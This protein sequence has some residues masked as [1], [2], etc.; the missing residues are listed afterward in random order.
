M[1]RE[2][3]PSSEGD[4]LDVAE[5]AELG[6]VLEAY[7]ADIEAGRP[8]ESE[9]LLAAHP[10][11]A[12]QLRACL[13]VMNLADRMVDVT[14]SASGEFRTMRRVDSTIAPAGRSVLSTLGPGPLPHVHLRDLPDES[15]PLIQPRSAEMPAQN[16]ASLGRYQLQGEIA[17][18]GMG[19][20]LKGRDV[21]LGRELAIK[22]LL[23]S[24]HDNPE[25]VSRFIEEAQ[26]GGQLQHPGIVPV[27][28]LGTF[29]DRRPY[30]AMKLVKGKTLAALLHDRTNPAHDLHRF[31]AIFEAVCQT[32][33]YAHARGVLHRDL[34]PSNVMVGSFG[35]VQVM[36][37][38]LA[39][40]LAS[41]GI[42]DEPANQQVQES[43]VVTDRSGSSRSGESQAGSVLGTPAYMAPEQAR[44][45]V[46]RVDERTDVFGLGAI[47]CEILTGR[48]PFVGSTREEIRGKAA[49]G[50]L[51]DA[52]HRLDSCAADAELIGHAHDCLKVKRD[53]RP[54]NAGEV[55]RRVTAFLASVQERLRAAEI[56]RVEAQARSAEERKRWQL[57]KALAALA[58][59]T[60][61]VIGG[62]WTYL[63]RQR[64]AQL[65][66]TTRLVTD[67]LAEAERFR[68][69][70]QSATTEDLS[71]WSEAI[72]AARHAHALVAD[73]EA[74]Q[75]LSQRV[76]TALFDIERE[77]DAAEKQAAE[78][79]RDREFVNKLE[80]IRVGR[81]DHWDPKQTD[82]EYT[83]AFRAF[84]IDFDQV[85]SKEGGLRIA[86]RSRPLEL[87]SYLDDWA[88]M[89]R[90]VSGNKDEAS[91]RGLLEAARAADP[92]PWR[93][94]LRAGIGRKGNDL[95]R[96]LA[97]D[98]QALTEQSTQSLLLL[99]LGLRDLGDRSR[100][101]RV[102]QLARRNLPNDFW[103]NYELGEFYLDAHSPDRPHAPLGQLA[104]VDE[105]IRYYSVAIAIRP[106]CGP[107]HNNLGQCL[108]ELGR[109]AEATAEFREAVRLMPKDSMKH[110]NLGLALNSEGKEEE[111]I[112]ELREA[113]R[114]KPDYGEALVEMGTALDELGRHDEA[115]RAYGEALRLES[116]YEKEHIHCNLG[117]SF[118]AKG[119]MDE[120]VA[121]Y[122]EALR[123]KPDDPDLHSNLGGVLFNQG[124]LESAIAE[125]REALRLNSNHDEAHANLAIAHRCR[126]EYAESIA[127]FRAARDLAKS[128]PEF[129]E[130][131]ELE[132][133]A[134]EQHMHLAPRLPAVLAGTLEPANA[135][136]M[137][138][139]AQLSYWKKLNRSSAQLW[140]KAFQA[141]PTLAQDLT[142]KNRRNAAYAAAL[143]GCGQG[144]VDPP[145]D[146]AAKAHWRSQAIDWL[147]AD[148]A[149]CAKVLDVGPPE[150]RMKIRKTLKS[151]MNYEL[152][153][154][155]DASA[156]TKFPEEEQ[157]ACRAFWAEV[158]ALL[159]K[160]G[161]AKAH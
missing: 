125:Y 29:P 63:A 43:V 48:P 45:E 149:S 72:A 36:D 96:K 38:G 113:L 19:A 88:L 15:D 153:G 74:D 75:L 161:K 68:G 16:G 106:T 34:K 60:T 20:I 110:C 135:T 49:L 62:G 77:R 133:A 98:E 130:E 59:F 99:A 33:A 85:D 80:M 4:E 14:G 44:G 147:R 11:I 104:R 2:R 37:W 93:G 17:R 5:D 115:I 108:F 100:E 64:S 83:A 123:T 55:A 78:F 27:Y 156:L 41:G 69:Q 76:A 23:E 13:K 40:V 51:I 129:V 87:A 94:A 30:F 9:R 159:A 122:H 18:G 160:S 127:E 139:F 24:H 12:G 84:G 82:V 121:E 102:L 8:A 3:N 70:A 119:R 116:N 137:L 157:K 22:V 158:D 124:K 56:A 65:M 97:D 61:G 151:W 140:A 131:V 53:E 58:L 6:L 28:E 81:S 111:A 90:R 46:E 107:A 71:R 25:V 134:T 95:P 47:L 103:A 154:L 118:E 145:L 10:A 120:A 128:N 136:E 79:R 73:G 155:R 1:S 112:G 92:N 141:E 142:A 32:V 143:S 89:R 67:A 42:A 7:L 54:R 39:K 148:L 91:W 109:V 101:E 152:A 35:E 52:L 144:N 126:G 26:I 150:A 132:L 66:A 86:Q 117:V 21:D 114:L 50:D 31:V 146:E 138:G 57:T 105:V